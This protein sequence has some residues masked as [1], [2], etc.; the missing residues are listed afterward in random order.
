MTSSSGVRRARIAA[1]AASFMLPADKGDDPLGIYAVMPAVVHEHGEPILRA[2]GR[3]RHH[4]W[5]PAHGNSLARQADRRGGDNRHRAPPKSRNDPR[6]RRS[7]QR[8]TQCC[9][10]RLALF[11]PRCW[12]KSSAV[13][14]P[15]IDSRAPSHIVRPMLRAH[16]Q[17]F[18]RSATG[19]GHQHR[20]WTE[21]S[22]VRKTARAT[23]RSDRAARVLPT[24]PR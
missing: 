24:R 12:A 18:A 23:E 3:S 7:A 5:V 15:A 13:A 9:H 17:R 19:M 21:A 4:R 2:R 10:A 16:L 11:P 8:A 22:R 6:R 1:N 14:L 20:R